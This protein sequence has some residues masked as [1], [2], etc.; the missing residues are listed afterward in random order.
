M[1]E[2]SAMTAWPPM[3]HMARV[4]AATPTPENRSSATLRMSTSGCTGSFLAMTTRPCQ[5]NS[6][7]GRRTTY[8]TRSPC[9][10]RAS[11]GLTTSH[12]T[13]PATP[14][15]Q[16]REPQRHG[17][18]GRAPSR[19]SR[20][21]NESWMA[22]G[23]CESVVGSR[24]SSSEL[25]TRPPGQGRASYRQRDS[26]RRNPRWRSRGGTLPNSSNHRSASCRW[27]GM[28]WLSSPS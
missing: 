11:G 14:I 12:R 8:T 17:R 28:R 25:W 7:S 19:I 20:S 18:F 23:G 5:Q 10:C 4:F 24:R 21:S 6:C 2:A 3:P 13:R 16:A 26:Y 15:S 22:C 1:G 9:T 27:S